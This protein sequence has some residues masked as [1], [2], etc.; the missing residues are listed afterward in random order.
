MSAITTVDLDLAQRFGGGSRK[1]VFVYF[2]STETNLSAQGASSYAHV[3][4]EGDSLRS[5]SFSL[6]AYDMTARQAMRL[7]ECWQQ[8]IREN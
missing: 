4:G 2:T 3:E 6:E 8:I 7:L 5:P 1:D